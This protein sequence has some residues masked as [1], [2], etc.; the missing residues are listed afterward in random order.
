MLKIE[1]R[2]ENARKRVEKA[3]AEQP[4]ARELENTGKL[5]AGESENTRELPTAIGE[6]ILQW[7]PE[8]FASE[9]GNEE[10]L[11]LLKNFL[12]ALAAHQEWLE[13]AKKQAGWSEYGEANV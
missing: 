2:V 6:L 13:K 1:E 4:P 11:R 10:A 9:G 7:F 3:G 5:P 8:L 12:T